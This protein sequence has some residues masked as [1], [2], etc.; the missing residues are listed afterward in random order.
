VVALKERWRNSKK[1]YGY[2]KISRTTE[3]G[4]ANWEAELQLAT[5]RLTAVGED[6]KTPSSDGRNVP[7]CRQRN[8][9]RPTI[10]FHGLG[11]VQ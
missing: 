2:L 8:A 1:E 4:C 7:K 10:D 3:G 5:D 9:A 6:W 11:H